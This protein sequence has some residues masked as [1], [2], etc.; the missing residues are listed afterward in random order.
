MHFTNMKER[1]EGS[2]SPFFIAWQQQ[3]QSD[4][5][6]ERNQPESKS[7]RKEDASI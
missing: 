2:L 5:D 3:R 7:K 1:R 4:D 6:N